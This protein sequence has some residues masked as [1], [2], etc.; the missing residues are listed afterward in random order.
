MNHYFTW[1]KP[2]STT[3]LLRHSSR[4]FVFSDNLISGVVV[5]DKV[6]PV[7]VGM[8]RQNNQAR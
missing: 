3:G 2:T 1:A 4:Q 8:V 7:P 5:Y 6:Q